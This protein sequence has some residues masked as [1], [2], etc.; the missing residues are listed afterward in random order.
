MRFL[1]RA[2]NIVTFRGWSFDIQ[3]IQASR[4]VARCGQ[5]LSFE[6]VV[7]NDGLR[8]G[9]VYPIVQL[10]NPYRR[11]KTLFDSD[12]DLKYEAKRPMVVS[13]IAPGC[14]G[15]F[16][17]PWTV[18]PAFPTGF[19]YLRCQIWS[20][21]RLYDPKSTPPFVASRRLLAQSRWKGGLEIMPAFEGDSTTTPAG[22]E[23]RPVPDHPSVF[24][25]YSWDSDDHKEW[26]LTLAEALVQRGVNVMLDQWHLQLGEETL[27]F[28]ERGCRDCNKILIVCTPK[29]VRRANARK[30]GVGYETIVTASLFAKTENKRRFIPIIR[31]YDIETSSPLPSYLGGTLF[32]DMEGD[33]W[34]ARPLTNLVRAIYERYELA[35]PPLGEPDI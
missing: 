8:V 19:L 28:M 21:S 27:H 23:F 29:Y 26:V 2:W 14:T 1:R 24:I 18:D 22:N 7:R 34:A 5:A 31:A 11:A 33:D 12:Q 17:I 13:D 10:A 4:A 20:P 9:T 35:P 32:L 16:S 30:G 15:S 6:G 3:S 25:T